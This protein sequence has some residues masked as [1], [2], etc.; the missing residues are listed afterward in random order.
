M[1]RVLKDMVYDAVGT[2][3]AT[4]Q[5][6]STML[7]PEYTNV[8]CVRRELRTLFREGKLMR[9]QDNDRSNRPFVYWRP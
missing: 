9:A 1:Y 8:D 3:P 6:V 5:D 2:F 4:A 7:L